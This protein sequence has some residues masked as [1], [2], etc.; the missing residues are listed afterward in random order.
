MSEG[1]NRLD[2]S[3]TLAVTVVTDLALFPLILFT[4]HTP[5][6]ARGV[7]LVVAYAVSQLVRATVQRGKSPA[8]I[9]Q[10]PGLWPLLA[11][12]CLINVGLFGIL[13]ARAPEI[14]PVLHLLLV[15]IG[16]LLFI[17]YGLSRIKRFR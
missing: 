16:S 8:A 6:L 11:I 3:V 7:S 13:S 4:L 1:G 12:T 10:V 5:I 2:W 14:R 17:A 15:W 9:L